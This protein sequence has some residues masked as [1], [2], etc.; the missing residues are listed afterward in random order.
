MTNHPMEELS[1]ILKRA[2]DLLSIKKT[3]SS[4]CFQ[5]KI[6]QMLILLLLSFPT[7]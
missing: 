7:L 2:V 3:F 4:L 1:E 5:V 6:C